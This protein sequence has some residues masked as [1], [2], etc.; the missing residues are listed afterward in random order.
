MTAILLS[1]RNLDSLYLHSTLCSILWT[2]II[3]LII[4]V[5]SPLSL[6]CKVLK[7]ISTP[8]STY[9]QNLSMAQGNIGEGISPVDGGGKNRTWIAHLPLSSSPFHQCQQESLHALS[10]AGTRCPPHASCH[11]PRLQLF[12]TVSFPGVQSA[13]YGLILSLVICV[14]AVAVFTTHILLLLPVLLSILGKNTSP[15]VPSFPFF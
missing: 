5:L 9:C 14:A 3:S 15:T 10:P 11:H 6:L 12:P 13:L 4:A 7:L 1:L 8:S 2:S